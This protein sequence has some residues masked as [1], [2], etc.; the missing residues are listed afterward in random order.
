MS[1]C[2]NKVQNVSVF[3]WSPSPAPPPLR[4][5]LQCS[6]TQSCRYFHPVWCVDLCRTVRCPYYVDQETESVRGTSVLR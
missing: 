2:S 6:L 5:P 1:C 4:S 3:C